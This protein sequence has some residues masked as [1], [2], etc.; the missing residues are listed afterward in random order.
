MGYFSKLDL[1][2]K[3]EYIDKSYYSFDDQLLQRYKDLKERYSE[4]LNS[5]APYVGENY[6]SYNDYHYAPVNS[7]KTIAEVCRALEV[8]AENLKKKCDITV[9]PYSYEE[10]NN[11]ISENEDIQ[12]EI[13]FIPMIFQHLTV[14]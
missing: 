7:F 10:Q 11:I 2:M 14:T 5:N 6:Y 1:Q 3:E 4:L 9:Y 12:L 13:T 8:T